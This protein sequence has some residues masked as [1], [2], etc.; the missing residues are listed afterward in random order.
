M[1]NRDKAEVYRLNFEKWKTNSLAEGGYFPIFNDLK[2]EYKLRNLSG[3]AVKL[4][5]FLGLMSGNM[6]GETWVAIDSI[7][8][9]FNKSKRTVSH[10]LAELEQSD[11]IKRMQLHPNGPSHTFLL[12][13]GKSNSNE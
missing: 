13:Y 4:Y 2:D 7:A 10:W 8:T 5:V 12:P 6:T 11:L 9:Y 3:N 1:S